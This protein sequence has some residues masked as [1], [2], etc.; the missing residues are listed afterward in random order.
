MDQLLDILSY[1]RAMLTQL[2]LVATIFGAFSMSGVVALLVG[3]NRD[4]LHRFLFVTLCLASLAFIFAASLDA[5]WL[6]ASARKANSQLS[7][8]RL[9]ALLDLGDYVVEA[10]VLGAFTLVAAVSG[11]GFAF[12][13]RLG[14]VVAALGIASAVLLVVL[15]R[16]L[17]IALS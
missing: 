16:K 17:D 12:S 6:P 2:L 14:W 9:R 7:P 11:F 13:R 4:R 1:K 5:V 8:E 15:F 10:V 3:P